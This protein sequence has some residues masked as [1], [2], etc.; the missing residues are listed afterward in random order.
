MVILM[1]EITI[2][3]IFEITIKEKTLANLYNVGDTI[4]KETL[5]DISKNFLELNID[6]HV[7][8]GNNLMSLLTIEA[9]KE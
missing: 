5:Y 2:K 8:N 7:N 4:N 3:G 6:N 9:V 1:K